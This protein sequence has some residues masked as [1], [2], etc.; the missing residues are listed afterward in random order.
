M[1]TVTFRHADGRST[2]TDAKDGQSLMQAAVA[3]NIHEILAECGGVA[4]CGTCHVRIAADWSDHLSPP[5]E[6]EQ[7]MIECLADPTPQS[8]LSCQI[9]LTQALDGLT[10]DLPGSQV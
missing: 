1:V 8:R 2:T 10:V 4:A 7:A 9:P 5:D 6:M 3:A